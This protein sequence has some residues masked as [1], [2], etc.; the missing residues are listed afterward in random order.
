VCLTGQREPISIGLRQP[1]Q[2]APEALR[3]AI[4]DFL[5]EVSSFAQELDTDVIKRAEDVKSEMEKV[6]AACS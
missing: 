4:D 2:V 5:E 6:V 1:R 3:K